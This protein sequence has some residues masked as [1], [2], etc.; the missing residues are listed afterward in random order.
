MI[1]CVEAS[2]RRLNRQAQGGGV[3]LQWRAAV[4]E[5]CHCFRKEKELE[6]WISKLTC[7]PTIKTY[8]HTASK[9]TFPSQNSETP[10]YNEGRGWADTNLKPYR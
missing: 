7:H 2:P 1:R 6:L 10:N 9:A 8:H 3:S 4:R 5:T